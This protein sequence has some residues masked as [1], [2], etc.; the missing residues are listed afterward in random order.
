ML[1]RA[2]EHET[3][4]LLSSERSTKR[5]VYCP[6]EPE[7]QLLAFSPSARRLPWSVLKQAKTE[8]A[9]NR[10]CRREYIVQRKQEA[11]VFMMKGGGSIITV[12]I[13]AIVRIY[14]FFF[15]PPAFFFLKKKNLER[16]LRG[17]PS[18]LS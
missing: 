1:L 9:Q 2:R 10:C 13:T 16:V 4:A 8:R 3:P 18:R 7:A 17:S 6:C 15:F 5:P 11:C 14:L 12:I